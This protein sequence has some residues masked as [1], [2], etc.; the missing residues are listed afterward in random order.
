VG[1]AQSRELGVTD[2]KQPK[3]VGDAEF[4][5]T[6]DRAL[7]L[8]STVALTLESSQGQSNQPVEPE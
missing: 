4:T 6:A 1:A 7:A 2:A 5:D 8:A 3:N